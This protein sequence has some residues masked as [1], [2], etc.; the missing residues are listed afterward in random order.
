VM[1]VIDPTTGRGMGEPVWVG[2]WMG[3]VYTWT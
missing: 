3:F 1:V 2:G